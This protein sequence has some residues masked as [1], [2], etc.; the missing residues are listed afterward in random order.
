LRDH[1]D[2]FGVVRGLRVKRIGV[3]SLRIEQL[4]LEHAWVT[5]AVVGVAVR[6]I[7]VVR[8]L[9]QP[10]WREGDLIAMARGFTRESLNP[11]F[12]RIAWR[13]TTS[14]I[15]ESEFPLVSW[16]TSIIW[17]L[18][19]EHNVIIRAVPFLA[20][21]ATLVV[22]GRFAVTRLGRRAGWLATAVVAVN[23]LTVFT[24]VSAQSDAVMLLGAVV[25]V[26]ATWNWQHREPGDV[27]RTD[28]LMVAAGLALAGL[29]KLTGLHVG[30]V[31]AGIIVS[32]QGWRG[33]LRRSTVVAGAV[34]ALIPLAWT[35]FSRR[36]Y[37]ST[38]LSL[39][40]SNERHW[41]GLDLFKEPSLIGGMIRH[42]LRYVWLLIGVVLAGLAIVKRHRELI[43]R[44]A[45]IWLLSVA[46][47]LLAAGR[48]T[49][50]SWAFY[51][52]VAAVPP[53]ALLIGCG[54][55]T[56]W[57]WSGRR[58]RHMT[59]G[60]SLVLA[61]MAV[62]TLVLATRS[63]WL[64]ARPQ[65]ASPLY[66]CA[67]QFDDRIGTDDLVLTSG[68]TRLDSAGNAVAFDASYMFEW[69]DTLGWTI[70]IED[71]SP[72]EVQRYAALGARWFIVERDALAAAPA[73]TQDAIIGDYRTVDQCNAAFLL[74][75]S[76]PETP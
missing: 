55:E 69:T 40:I 38:G 76:R 65:P 72:A 43:V 41:A 20:G 18:F 3:A 36:H 22:F 74:D 27:R 60:T 63:S 44:I 42:E 32:R 62:I 67:Q 12:P 17:R 56:G 48:T 45:I 16:I 53:A 50:D 54:L 52:H 6:F 61:G 28:Q 33:L 47:M 14:G 71:Q 19:G 35:V 37:N 46:F 57:T 59:G 73:K 4:R 49:G 70:P 1:L 64:L 66:L 15:T 58:A 21:M 31:V 26:T 25:A 9:N 10:S 7:S 24:S 8:P 13:G 68:G 23:P 11:F 51:Y 2:R 75:L 30:L 29:M 5:G 34:G 39:G